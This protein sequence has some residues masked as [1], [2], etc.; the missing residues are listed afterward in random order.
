MRHLLPIAVIAA[1]LTAA[2]A[3]APA[4]ENGILAGMK[5]RTEPLLY[6]L[7][8]L[9]SP[10]KLGGTDPEKGVDCSGFVRH[11]YKKTSDAE[12]PHNAK[13]MSQKGEAVAKE[14]LKPGDLVFFDTLRRPYSHVGI[15]AGDGK[16]VHASSSRSKQVMVSNMND[17]YWSKRFNGARRLPGGTEKP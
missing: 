14:N 2:T 5:E 6:A 17:G 3:P 4:E 16:F 13:A 7:G 9:G 11:V 10:Y 15:Y 12:L 8:L 1:V